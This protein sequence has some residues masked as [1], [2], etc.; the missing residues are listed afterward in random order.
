MKIILLCCCLFALKIVNADQPRQNFSFKSSNNLFELKPSDTIFAD[1]TVYMDTIYTTEKDYYLYTY[2]H[3][4]NYVW[5]LYDLS[6]NK[7]LYSIYNE[8]I[9]IA[10]KTALI[11]NDGQYV[12]IVDDYSGGYAFHDL[13]VVH[14][15]HRDMRV[16][17]FNLGDLLNSM[18]NVSYSVSHMRWCL[19]A[20]LSDL[21]KIEIK[22]FEYYTYEINPSGEVV[23]KTSDP[24]IQEEDDIVSAKI[25]RIEKDRY[26]FK[27][28]QSVRNKNA[29][30]RT[31]ESNVS[32][33]TM[34]EI[35][36]R[37][38]SSRLTKKNKMETS[39]NQTFVLRND[40]PIITGIRFPHYTKD[41]NCFIFDMLKD[42]MP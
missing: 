1:K 39:F 21:N 42:S 3:A 24:R 31:F 9:R 10:S 16:K 19:K 38:Y 29:I 15:Y 13:E 17:T 36:G 28:Y 26:E 4:D 41:T 34:K 5:S 33:D 18:C 37:F 32:D 30:G 35:H 6:N 7:I 20:S 23:S 12:V 27:I 22:T 11:S 40:L 2:T 14:I 8:N 25:R